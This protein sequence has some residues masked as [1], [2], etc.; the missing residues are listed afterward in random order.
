LV[1]DYDCGFLLDLAHAS[2][3]AKYFGMDEHEYIEQLPVERV[4][5]I[6]VAGIE[7]RADG[8][9][10]DHV[11]MGDEGWALVEW[12]VDQIRT[13]RWPRPW[14]MTLEYGGVG[15]GFEEHTDPDAILE[16]T[17]RLHD[18]ARSIEP[19]GADDVARESHQTDPGKSRN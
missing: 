9:W 14:V 7:R 2:I 1:H 17:P 3:T 10:Y 4:R 13:G 8:L 15:P 18:L 19:G 5:E 6:H 12:A 11:P 16:Q